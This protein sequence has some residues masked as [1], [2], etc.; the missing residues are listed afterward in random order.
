MNLRDIPAHPILYLISIEDVVQSPLIRSQ[1]FSTLENI[2]AQSP[3]FPL[4]VVS[5]YPILNWIRFR[6]ELKGLGVELAGKGI[7]LRTIPLVFLTRYFYIPWALF[8]PYWIQALVAALWISLRLRPAIV[9]CRS[10]PA[11][12]VG[13]LTKWL[14]GSKLIFDTRAL[15]PEEGAVRRVS[16]KAVMFDRFSL[17]MWR[18]VERSIVQRADAVVFVSH[19]FEDMFA[20]RYGQS[21][22]RFVTIPTTTGIPAWEDL[23]TWRSQVHQKLDLGGRMVVGYVGS[24]FEPA[25]ALDLF[26]RLVQAMPDRQFHFLLLVSTRAEGD[27]MAYTAHLRE[28]VQRQL[29]TCHG[30]TV[31]SVPHYQVS[32]YLAG[33]DLAAQ[34]AGLPEDMAQSKLYHRMASTVLA[35]KFVE[36]LACG[37]PVFVSKWHG[38][39]AELVQQHDL[40]VVY[41]Q[42]SSDD[43]AAWL[44]RWSQDRD[45]F[46]TRAWGFAKEHFA[47]DVVAARYSDLY[48]HL[49]NHSL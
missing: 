40:G 1:V 43:M 38:A 16:G 8:L 19:P 36:Y 12:V 20:S 4:I 46:R 10:Y 21:G 6:R 28:L 23:S 34:P 9:H 3:G 37:L 49:L 17:G 24:W 13:R 33:V 31:L 42:V 41:D 27:L 11:A 48:H 14:S 2:A 22:A 45:A 18:R 44:V 5:L 30:C 25:Y 7:T 15:Y 26:Q 29:G 35:V 32:W 39:A 47:I